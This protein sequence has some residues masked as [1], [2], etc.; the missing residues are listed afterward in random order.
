MLF[1]RP[2]LPAYSDLA[3]ISWTA[4]HV[5]PPPKPYEA[6]ILYLVTHRRSSELVESLRSVQVNLTTGNW[7]IILIHSGDFDDDD[8]KTTLLSEVRQSSSSQA[9]VD[10]LE[11]I[12]ANF[13]LP[14]GVEHDV[15]VLDPVFRHV[16]PGYHQMCA[17]YS[18]QIFELPRLRDV[19]Y[20]M[21]LDS[22]SYINARSCF[23]PFERMHT[24]NLHYAYKQTGADPGFV[25]RGMWTLID[26]YAREH[27]AMEVQLEQ[28]QWHWPGSRNKEWFS[29]EKDEPIGSYHN[30]FEVVRLD[31]F[32]RKDVKAWFDELQS[33]PE[34]FYKYRWGDAPL[35]YATVNMHFDMQ[36]EVGHFCDMPYFHQYS[37]ELCKCQS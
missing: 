8:R 1:W 11:F 14:P 3:S 30:S 12:R 24:R 27:P 22:D 34:R 37:Y 9:F 7:P 33:V 16:W 25:I 15:D 19:T 10:R 35:R 29:E 2:P 21:R 4:V 5:A 28:N 31:A 26:D 23:D 36:T 17:F 18:Y 20:Y 6:V 32:R 13:T